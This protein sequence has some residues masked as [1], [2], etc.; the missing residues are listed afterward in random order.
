MAHVKRNQPQRVESTEIKREKGCQPVPCALPSATRSRTAFDVAAVCPYDNM[1]EKGKSPGRAEREALSRIGS[2]LHY[3][4][5]NAKRLFHML[6]ALAFMI[7]TVAGATLTYDEWL[8]YREAPQL[9]VTRIT[10]FGFG[11]F[12]VFLAILC[13][14]SFV[15]ARN[16]R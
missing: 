8:H 11:A 5:L 10:M 1:A 9:N 15:R 3:W 16:V 4:F 13:L 7:L 6:V 14:Y 12:T 2:L